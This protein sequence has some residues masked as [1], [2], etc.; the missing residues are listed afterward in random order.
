MKNKKIIIFVVILV[1]MF[2][3]FSVTCFAAYDGYD[4]VGDYVFNTD[5]VLVDGNLPSGDVKFSCGSDVFQSMYVA[6][7]SGTGGQFWSLYY[8]PFDSNSE[9]Y[10]VYS[11]GSGWVSDDYRFIYIIDCSE[12]SSIEANFLAAN[13]LRDVKFGWYYEIRDVL[14]ETIFYDGIVPPEAEFGLSLIS[15]IL[16]VCA[17]LLPVLFAFGIFLWALK[18]V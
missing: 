9:S 12:V 6:P 5:L 17:I 14:V 18:R 1:L 7:E 2:S 4:Y 8:V 15:L 13:E 11:N 3:A 10:L 16:C